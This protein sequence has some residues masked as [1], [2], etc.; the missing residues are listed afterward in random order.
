V[1]EKLKT[2]N[3]LF[4]EIIDKLQDFDTA[5]QIRISD[6]IFGGSG[7]EQFVRLLDQ[8]RGYLEDA[9]ERA[10][11]LGLVLDEETLKKADVLEKKFQEIE[12]R[13]G[14]GIK[15]AIISAAEAFNLFGIAEQNAAQKVNDKIQE[16]RASAESQLEALFLAKNTPGMGAGIMDSE[17]QAVRDQISALTLD[18]VDAQ[19]RKD[20]LTGQAGSFRSSQETGLGYKPPTPEKALSLAPIRTGGG[21]KSEAEKARES[22]DKLIESLMREQQ[23]LLTLDPI[24][25]KVIQNLS[26]MSGATDAQKAAIEQL[27]VANENISQQQ[28]SMAAISGMFESATMSA[29]DSIISGSGSAEDAVKS[30]AKQL[31]LAAAQAA[32]FG[33]GPLSGLFGGG[34]GGGGAGGLF[35][36]LLGGAGK[37]FSFEGGGFTGSGSRTGGLDGKGGYMAMVHPNESVID[38]TKA[39]GKAGV[40]PFAPVYNIDAR[41]AD[42]GAVARIERSLQ[43]RDRNFYRS[44]NSA[45]AQKQLRG[46][47]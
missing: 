24:Q 23:V 31:A 33:S 3:L 21:G 29:L 7:G 9:S 35:G 1:A 4:E 32:L 28:Q 20:K 12:K 30:L 19:N 14:V 40:S 41:G 42:A 18:I 47:K 36:S 27:T 15:S 8:G 11:E 16:A 45:T 17:I 43:E 34:K 26:S 6:E 39:S 38:H 5:A 46:V 2:P 13:I 10:R 44:V 22:A 25:K 37:L